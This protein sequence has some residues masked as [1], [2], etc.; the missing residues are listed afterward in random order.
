MSLGKVSVCL[1]VPALWKD[2]KFFNN[3]GIIERFVL[4]GTLK[5]M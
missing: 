3:H 2:H 5:I 4:A 1:S